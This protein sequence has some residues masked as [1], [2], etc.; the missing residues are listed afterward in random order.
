MTN[1]KSGPE[2][3]PYYPPSLSELI[4]LIFHTGP[5]GVR[6]ELDTLSQ[7]LGHEVIVEVDWQGLL[8][9]YGE[10]KD[11]K[12][13]HG[14]CDI[15]YAWCI[16]LR[17]ITSDPERDDWMVELLTRVVESG[18][19]LRVVVDVWDSAKLG[20][21]WSDERRGFV[22]HMPKHFL[23]VRRVVLS[24]YNV[25]RD[26]FKK[27]FASCEF[28]ATEEGKK[29]SKPE[30]GMRTGTAPEL[31]SGLEEL[32]LRD[33]DSMGEGSSGAAG[34]M[35]ANAANSKTTTGITTASSSAGPTLNATPFPTLDSVPS[36]LELC[37]MPPYHLTITEDS[38]GWIRLRGSHGPS[39]RF[40]DLYISKWTPNVLMESED[41]PPMEGCS[42]EHGNH[43]GTF[44]N[45][46]RTLK[47]RQ[48]VSLAHVRRPLSMTA[49]MVLAIVQGT[50]GY[51]VVWQGS[52]EYRLRRDE[53][54]E[55]QE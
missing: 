4:I 27:I 40:I 17:E 20:T 28:Q 54:F 33:D 7:R 23:F 36:L 49:P 30:L 8:D 22:V 37:S 53:P 2:P 34:V 47:I 11:P 12:I 39:I 16:E 51:K 21:S 52:G 24:G 32:G 6:T 26:Q 48:D 38:N 15:I 29:V 55:M 10:Q 41:M 19:K 43:T 3:P 50:L 18:G 9:Q 46:M 25:I 13:V 1:L 5:S 44:N 45:P 14:V 42:M 35:S 31:A